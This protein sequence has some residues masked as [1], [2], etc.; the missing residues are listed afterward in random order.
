MEGNVPKAVKDPAM[1]SEAQEAGSTVSRRQDKCFISV[2]PPDLLLQCAEFLDDTRTLCR[3]CEVSHGWLVTLD[4][5]E[6]GRR[7]WRPVFYRL[8]ANGDI[9]AATD[10]R[11]QPRRQLKVYDLG[12]SAGQSC[13]DSPGFAE[14]QGASLMP[15]VA[16]T[17]VLPSLAS[18]ARQSEIE[19]LHS[20][21]GGTPGSDVASAT[22]T[23]RRSSA[24]SVCG[25]IQRE[26]Y[27]GRDC[28]MCASSLVLTPSRASLNIPRVAYT[29]VNLSESAASATKSARIAPM[30][31]PGSV[32]KSGRGT[33]TANIVGGIRKTNG[34]DG[35]R[36]DE[37]ETDDESDIDWHFLVKRLAEEKRIVSGWG[38]LHYGW[39]W[40]QGALQV[41]CL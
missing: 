38:T 21:S 29:R 22:G 26:G 31:I 41:R 39:V 14:A 23:P 19:G 15:S 13:A 3:V 10:S 37:E 20:A 17:P 33:S 11:G 18:R 16:R 28:E 25:L 8:R 30:D 34:S 2:L 9:H 32:D 4:G 35:G 27:I 24:C 12:S 7:L 36:D 6:A 40:L 5:L 1:I